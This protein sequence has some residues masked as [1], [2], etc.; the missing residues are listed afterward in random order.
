[1]R[2]TTFHLTFFSA[3]LATLLIQMTGIETSQAANAKENYQWYCSQCHGS[4]GKGAG[5]NAK[6]STLGLNL[7]EMSVAP[8]NHTSAKDME[9][10][11]DNDLFQAIKGGGVAVSKSSLM[12]PFGKTMSESDMKDLVK[13]LRELCKCKGK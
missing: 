10:L 7:P 5:V 9:T 13:Y 1:M 12:P 8:R 11:S 6:P 4:D 3:C 2:R